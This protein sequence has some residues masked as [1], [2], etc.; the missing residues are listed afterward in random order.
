MTSTESDTTANSSTTGSGASS[1][2]ESG[3]TP[4]RSGGVTATD[5]LVTRVTRR[6][7]KS[8]KAVR[9]LVTGRLRVYHVDR[10][11]IVAECKGDSGELYTLGWLPLAGGYRWDCTCPARR[12]CSHLMALQCVTAVAR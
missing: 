5:R 7:T 2:S 1:E 3:P 12:D 8:D 4:L 10:K 6:E 11:S 9:L